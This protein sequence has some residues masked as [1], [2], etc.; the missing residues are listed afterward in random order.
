MLPIV[1]LR[2]RLR[3][4]PEKEMFRIKRDKNGDIVFKLSGRMDSERVGELK[5]LLNAEAEG[6]RVVLDLSELI[7]VNE[8]A[9]RFLADF[10]ASG[11]ELKNCPAYIRKWITRLRGSC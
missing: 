3:G 1:G 4:L 5:T 8:D 6:R 10:E 7:L 11:I 2:Q 9:V